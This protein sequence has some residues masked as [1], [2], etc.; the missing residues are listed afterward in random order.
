VHDPITDVEYIE[1]P[2]KARHIC[3]MS[4]KSEAGKNFNGTVFK[5]IKMWIASMSS[6]IPKSCKEKTPIEHVADVCTKLMPNF[7]NE[8]VKVVVD[9]NKL[10]GS[11]TGELTLKKVFPSKLKDVSDMSFVPRYG[12]YIVYPTSNEKEKKDKSDSNGKE[13]LQ[14]KEETN[15]EKD[16]AN[17]IVKKN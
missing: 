8:P 7:F 15:D 13:E 9:N 2:G 1:Y 16:T 17:A 5:L 4:H 10:I 14:G 3:L 6:L 12:E 11:S